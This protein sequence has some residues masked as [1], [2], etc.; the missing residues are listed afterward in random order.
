MIRWIRPATVAEL[1]SALVHNT[2]AGRDTAAAHPAAAVAPAT[3]NFPRYTALT[4]SEDTVQ[5]ALE[6]MNR[7]GTWDKRV[8]IN[9]ATAMLAADADGICASQKPAGAGALLINGAATAGGVF[10][11]G[12]TMVGRRCTITS[13]ADDSGRTFTFT[14]RSALNGTD[15][16]ITQAGPNNTTATVGTLLQHVMVDTLTA[17]S[18]DG[19]TTG[20]I[21]VG[22]DVCFLIQSPILAKKTRVNNPGIN[23]TA[24]GVGYAY[25]GATTLVDAGLSGVCT[26][27]VL[28]PAAG[29]RTVSFAATGG[30]TA[31]KVLG[32]ALESGAAEKLASFTIEIDGTTA[33]IRNAGVEA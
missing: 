8:V 9:G 16:T 7:A 19:A 5:K 28:Q 15:Y 13:D 23:F 11:T 10:T 12:S 1:I 18:V 4:A 24:Y 29:A 26:L 22:F 30:L 2:I 3:T 25:N 21:T 20:N 33:V 31:A 17:I 27:E 14:F 6:A 32:A